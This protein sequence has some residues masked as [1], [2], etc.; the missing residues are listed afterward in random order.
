[1]DGKGSRRLSSR[2]DRKRRW[3]VVEF[4]KKSGKFLVLHK[5]S[6]LAGILIT[7]MVI[8]LFGVVSRFQVPSFNNPPTGGTTVINY[9]TFKE[10]VSAGNVLAVSIQNDEVNGLLVHS[11]QQGQ[12]AKNAQASI[13]AKQ[14]SLDFTAWSHYLGG[15]SSWATTPVTN[16]IDESVSYTH[17]YPMVAML[18]LCPC[19]YMRM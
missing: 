6:F 9:S 17:A 19:F 10:Q 14:R 1:M 18:R 12:T 5:Q 4:G 11:L 8:L 2:N 3:N 13:D 16:T 7:G 15:S